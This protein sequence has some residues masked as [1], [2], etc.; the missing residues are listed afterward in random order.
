MSFLDDM[1][2]V[3][4]KAR[5]I[6]STGIEDNKG[7]KA[8]L[9]RLGS[10]ARIIESHEI[11]M[12]DKISKIRTHYEKEVYE[13]VVDYRDL[14]AETKTYCEAFQSQILAEFAKEGAKTADLGVGTIAYRQTPG[15]LHIV[16]KDEQAACQELID[17]GFENAV[18]VEYVLLKDVVK[19]LWDKISGKVT[20]LEVKGGGKE[21]VVITPTK[22]RLK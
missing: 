12:N 11:E 19:G 3:L 1:L 14:F 15:S 18:K 8:A 10:L 22:E 6:K 21:S 7:L 2:K 4:P 16:G 13:Q 5:K 20:L 17:K 9:E